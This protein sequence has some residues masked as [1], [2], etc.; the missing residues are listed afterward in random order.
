LQSFKTAGN[1]EKS[2]RD[3]ICLPKSFFL[4]GIAWIVIRIQAISPGVEREKRSIVD[5]ALA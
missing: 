5:I 2:N 3:L 4:L 1:I